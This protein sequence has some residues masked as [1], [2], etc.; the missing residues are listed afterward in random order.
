ML[1]DVVLVVGGLGVLAVGADNFVVG[2]ARV[3]VR[4]KV[5]PVVVGAVIVGFGTGM[6]ELLVSSSA[7][8]QGSLE[9][10][11]GNVV[12]SNLANLTLVL[13]VAGLLT[14]VETLPR[15]VRREAPLSLAG[16]VVLAVLMQNGLTRAEA[17]V[18]LLG[19]VLG[20]VLMLRATD[21][22]TETPA[23]MTAIDDFVDEV[24]EFVEEEDEQELKDVV[25]ASQLRDVLR[26]VV[27]LLATVGGAQLLV[28]G[29][30]DVA[31]EF[32]L[33]GGFVGLTLVAVGTSLP[34]LVTAVQS[35][36]RGETALLAGN[37][38]GSNI[39]NSTAVAG[40]A[41]MIGPGPLADRGLTL[42]AAGSMVTVAVLAWGFLGL[43][44]RLRRW[45]AGVLIAVYAASVPFTT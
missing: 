18:L 6:P 44:G 10:A 42:W 20:V 31:A 36:R 30:Q 16:L 17:V 13:G 9:L 24:E 14:R 7:A 2:A 39:F 37:V 23:D 26:T 22:P 27:G 19:L 41:A 29:A 12:G 15:V 45:E 25:A 1:F 11:I 4:Y 40:T 32:G 28:V 21:A 35:A 34:E 38:L 8:A 43:G 3:S 33:S 5:S